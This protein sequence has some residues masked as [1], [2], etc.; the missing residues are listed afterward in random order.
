MAEAAQ[1]ASAE[2]EG[3]VGITEYLTPGEGFSA[4]TKQRFTDFIVNEVGLSGHIV[5]LSA[6]AEAPEQQPGTAEAASAGLDA[7]AAL[8]AEVGDE[9]AQAL[10]DLQAQATGARGAAQAASELLLPR[11]DPPPPAE[12]P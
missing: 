2:R 3:A 8:A 6:F 7:E 1:H 4:I 5:R 10:L 11:D 12:E 9:L